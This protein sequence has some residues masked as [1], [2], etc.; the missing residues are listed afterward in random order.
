M[1]KTDVIR[2][3]DLPSEK[4][5]VLKELEDDENIPVIEMSTITD[6]GVMDV[7]NQTCERLLSF[8]VDQKIK[9]KKVNLYYFIMYNI[10]PIY[11]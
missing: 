11:F 2:L 10:F 3:A 6:F 7:K 8:R 5:S 1:N 4:R 9:T